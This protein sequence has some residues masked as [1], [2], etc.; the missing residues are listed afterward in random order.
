MQQL[1][2]RDDNRSWSRSPLVYVPWPQPEPPITLRPT[3]EQDAPQ[4]YKKKKST[5]LDD[6]L[7]FSNNINEISF[8]AWRAEMRNKLRQNTDYYKSKEDHIGYVFGRTKGDARE[9]LLTW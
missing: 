5:R 8:E 3:I 7:C 9:H 4:L 6:P 2:L 1:L